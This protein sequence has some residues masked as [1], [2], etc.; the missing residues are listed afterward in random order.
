MP[1]S[2]GREFTDASVFWSLRL[3]SVLFLAGELLPALELSQASCGSDVSPVSVSLPGAGWDE[4]SL[5]LSPRELCP[6]CPGLSA[7]PPASLGTVPGPQPQVAAAGGPARGTE[8]P[9]GAAGAQQELPGPSSGR[10]GASC[11]ARDALAELGSS[12]SGSS[13]QG[14][15]A[16]DRLE[17]DRGSQSSGLGSDSSQ[18]QE[19]HSLMGSGALQELRELLAQAED[20]AASWSHPAVPRASC[21]DTREPSLGLG[22]DE[23]DPRDSS[24]GKNWI[25]QLQERLPWDG[26]VTQRGVRGQGLGRNA[27]GSDSCP[28]GW[29]NPLAVSLRGSEG[30]KG[31]SQEPRTGKSAGRSEPEGCSSSV[32]TDRNQGLAQSSASSELST[33]TA[34][35][36]GHAPLLEPLGTVPPVP[37]GSQGSLSRAGGPAGTRGSDGS[38]SGDS[39]SARVRSLLGQPRGSATLQSAR[40]GS[41]CPW[42]R[43]GSSSSS[44]GDSLAA[45]V[46]SLLG[47]AAPG[48][49]ASHILRSAEEQESKIRGEDTPRVPLSPAVPLAHPGLGVCVQGSLGL[50]WVQGDGIH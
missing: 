16:G 36:L 1:S 31:M 35:E 19:G 23:Q 22:R 17:L 5:S 10:E 11:C 49:S 26:A 34:P 44:T 43:A 25:P 41:G 18:G 32:A 4:L 40:P 14:W 27:L 37:G 47:T 28:L 48:S 8:C 30:L 39:L 15:A 3:T 13:R 2:R 24:L 46:R 21:R 12:S 38:S 29:G 6:S 9:P 33:G 42:L 45:R 7:E 50:M 20:L